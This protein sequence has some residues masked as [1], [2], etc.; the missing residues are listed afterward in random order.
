MLHCS[1]M[2]GGG[3]G[4]WRV[5]GGMDNATARAPLLRGRG[6][7]DGD[8]KAPF[9]EVRDFGPNPGGLKMLVYRPAG[10]QPKSPLVVAL[11]GCTQ[12]AAAFTLGAGWTALADRLGF[13]VLA[14]EQLVINNLNR[15]FNW[16]RP[17]DIDPAHG[18]VASI[19]AMV[20][21]LTKTAQLDADRVF[22]TGLSA[23]GAMANA[24]MAAYPQMFAGAAIIGGIPFGA[25]RNMREGLELM[26]GGELP[27]ASVQTLPAAA[28]LPRISVWQ[29]DADGVVNPRNAE[30]VA[31]Q[32]A[33][34]HG[35]PETPDAVEAA[36]GRIRSVW[37]S[38]LGELPVIEL[39]LVHG[40]GHGLPLS[41]GGEDDVGAPAPFM[42]DVGLSSTREI[43]KFWRLDRQDSPPVAV[44]QPPPSRTSALER[45]RQGAARALG[46]IRRRF[47]NGA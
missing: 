22:I 14:P 10:L 18:E 1:I 45:V 27:A 25:A 19:A 12:R 21:Y 9:V 32:W 29:G 24:V 8:V 44:S 15:C 3:S 35:L 39:N 5:V 4:A 46:S 28:R 11:H 23:G 40:M 43:A 42:L 2:I 20:V 36:P 13:A 38:R 33:D 7:P 47:S 37:R 31:A 30:A 6:E 16:F 17:R 34:A 41:T 26:R